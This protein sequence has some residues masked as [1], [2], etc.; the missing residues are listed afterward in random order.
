[1]NE[2]PMQVHITHNYAENR[3]DHAAEVIV[4]KTYDPSET[5]EAM[6]RRV[7]GYP[8]PSWRSADPTAFITIRVVD[9]TEPREGSD[10]IPPF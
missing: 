2:Q 10:G 9:G 8:V 1:M 5:V 7:M 4:A 6:I 3:G